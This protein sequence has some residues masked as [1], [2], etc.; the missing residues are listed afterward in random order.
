M[1]SERAQHAAKE[2]GLID[3]LGADHVF[4]SVE[5]AIRKRPA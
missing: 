1:S 2:T 3:A 4:R 5:E